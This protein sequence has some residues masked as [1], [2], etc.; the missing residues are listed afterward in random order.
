MYDT[1]SIVGM[2]P[3]DTFARNDPDSGRDIDKLT[4]DKDIDMSVYVK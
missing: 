4:V 3:I 2:H 1:S